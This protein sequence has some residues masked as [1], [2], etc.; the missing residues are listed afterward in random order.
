MKMFA[1]ALFLA[2][3]LPLVAAGP[4]AWKL[5]SSTLTYTVTHKLHTVR[6]VSTQSRGKG[7]CGQDGCQFLIAAPVNS[8]DSGDANRDQHMLEAVRGA[9]NPIVSVK[10]NL[11]EAP[12]AG[13]F[14]ADLDV[15]FAG[16]KHTYK[17]VDFSVEELP[18]GARR[19][20]GTVPLN[21]QDFG[22]KPPSLLTIPIKSEA[23]LRVEMTWKTQ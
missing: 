7:V 21:I 15:D 20:T 1:L 3:P 8:F 19:L 18:S 9:K 12:A 16:Q 22:I 10:T 14:K 13:T 23:P 5:E 4:N 2:A 11:A 17:S 6:G